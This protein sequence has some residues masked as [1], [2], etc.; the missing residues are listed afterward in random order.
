MFD[1][2][3]YLST[4]L[5]LTKCTYQYRFAGADSLARVDQGIAA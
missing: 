5:T 2:P 4:G 3:T 1:N